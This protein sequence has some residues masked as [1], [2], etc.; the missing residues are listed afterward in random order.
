[1]VFWSVSR[2]FRRRMPAQGIV[3]IWTLLVLGGCATRMPETGLENG[4]LRPC[5][6]TPNCVSSLSTDALHRVEPLTYVGDVA[7]GKR[8]LKLTLD[9]LPRTRIVTESDRYLH[10]EFTTKIMR[11]VDDVEFLIDEGGGTIHVRSASRVGK[12]DLGANRKR[13]EEIRSVLAQVRQ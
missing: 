7:E 13:V 12:G 9:R 4:S 10:V 6:S 2:R 11:F 5:P 1:M 3:A 8:L